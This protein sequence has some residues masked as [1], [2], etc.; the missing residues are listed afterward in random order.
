MT[1]TDTMFDVAIVG[2]GISGLAAAHA[3][4]TAE[5]PL[6][7]VVLEGSDRWGG[8]IQTERLGLAGT[9]PFILEAGPDS[10]I[11]QKPW[12]LQLARQLGMSEQLLPTN[13]ER[14]QTFVLNRGR[15]VPLPDGVM[16][17]VPTKFRPFLFSPLISLPG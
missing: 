13:D 12:A 15:P 4:Q 7:Y 14:R 9:D 11:T 5:S 2:G 3:L 17:I 10:F 1:M 6:N 16:L 8:K